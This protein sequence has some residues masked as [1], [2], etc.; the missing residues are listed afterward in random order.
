MKI[1]R[2]DYMAILNK[3]KSELVYDFRRTM[4][5]DYLRIKSY[6]KTAGI[7]VKTVIKWVSRYRESGLGGLK[8]LPRTPKH[9]Q[10]KVT[11]QMEREIL[12]WRDLTGFGAMRM[13]MELG[14]G[15]AA[16]TIYK[17]LV[18]NQRVKCRRKK[19]RK[20]RDLRKLKARLRPFQ[21]VQADSVPLE[22]LCTS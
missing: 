16:R 22:V 8:D 11:P 5:E 9:P 21:K 17:V 18:R 20:K 15:F 14:F 3:S 13:K 7:N 2:I 19:W 6:R 10:R 12:A 1:K 4:V